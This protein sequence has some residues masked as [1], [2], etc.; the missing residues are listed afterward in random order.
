MVIFAN[1]PGTNDPSEIIYDHDFYHRLASVGYGK[2][3]SIGHHHTFCSFEWK[4][5][6]TGRQNNRNL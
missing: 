4:M 1:K 2:T 5:D 6:K 3:I